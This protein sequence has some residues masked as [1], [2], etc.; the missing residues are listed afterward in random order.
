MSIFVDREKEFKDIL[1]LLKGDYP[2]CVSI[3][4]SPYIGKSSLAKRLFN[5]IGKLPNICSIYI[6]C[7]D[8]LTST[9]DAEIF[10]GILNKELLSILKLGNRLDNCEK[11]KNAN[12]ILFGDIIKALNNM[13][14]NS[15]IFLDSF[16]V[17]AENFV[18][19]NSC[20]LLNPLKSL[21]D[22][23]KNLA[24]VI[25]S[26]KK[27][28]EIDNK[29]SS[30]NLFTFKS[31]GLLNNTV[32]KLRQDI[33]QQRGL[34]SDL[35]D[36]HYSIIRR[37]AG[38][39]PCFNE[40]VCKYITEERN[41][42]RGV[43][44]E[45]LI[46]RL[47]EYYESLWKGISEE[48]QNVLKTMVEY[49]RKF[50]FIYKILRSPRLKRILERLIGKW[51]KDKIPS[52]LQKKMNNTGILEKKDGYYR[53][54]SDYFY[55]FINNKLEKGEGLFISSFKKIINEITSKEFFILIL[56]IITFYFAQQGRGTEA[57]FGIIGSIFSII[58]YF[59]K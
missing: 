49:E 41:L 5:E 21:N 7:N 8:D 54:F 30:W 36:E 10:F 31:V 50:F 23:N 3:Y 37:Y 24:F 6:D 32:E 29:L 40:L 27:L 58:S 52:Y 39:H 17:L 34:S 42:N 48:E 51:Y 35:N 56:C 53:L 15:I 2:Q 38:N 25:I 55:D 28:S 43:N 57:S 16:D 47:H 19:N 20:V 9:R 12:Y 59:K 14:R 26:Q 18:K 4:G 44:E 1:D 13:K 11:Y 46:D 33:F 45:E 22:K